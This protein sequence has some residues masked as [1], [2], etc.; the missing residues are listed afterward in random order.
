MLKLPV[1]LASAPSGTDVQGMR[2]WVKEVFAEGLLPAYR[3]KFEIK[4]RRPRQ[5]VQ[6]RSIFVHCSDGSGD[7][8]MWAYEPAAKSTS[9]R[10]AILMF[11][12]GGWIHGDPSADDGQSY[13][14]IESFSD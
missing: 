4:L 13:F 6:K 3:D 2:K 11:H 12:G 10:P 5:N 8:E 1:S 14:M 7:F 9:P